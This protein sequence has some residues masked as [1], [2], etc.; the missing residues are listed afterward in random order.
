MHLGDRLSAYIDNEL[1]PPARSAA[2]RHLSDCPPCRDELE[3]VARVRLRTRALPLQEAPLAL[4]APSA[5]VVALPVRRR[6]LVAAAAVATLVV[7]IGL[8]VNGNEAVPLQ[9]NPLVEQHVARA[10][11]DPGFNVIQVQAVVGR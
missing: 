1:D 3:G 8:G 5:E 6:V 9:L 10:S 2:E 7:G 4:F 11:L